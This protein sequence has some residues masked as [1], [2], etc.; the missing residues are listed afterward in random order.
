ME[1][2]FLKIKELQPFRGIVKDYSQRLPFYLDDWIVN[3]TD[4]KILSATLFIFFTSIGPAITFSLLI[5]HGTNGEIGVVEVLLG[6]GVS[7]IIAALFQGFPLVIWGVSGPVSVLTIA[8]RV[9]AMSW[10]LPFLPFFAWSQIWGGVILIL[11]AI[12][13]ASDS[14][15]CITTYTCETFGTLIGTIFL[16][17][18]IRGMVDIFGDSSLA[19]D[20]VLLQFILFIGVAITSYYLAQAHHWKVLFRFLRNAVSEYGAVISITLFSLV[21][22]LASHRLAD[23]IA[24]IPTLRVPSSF[25]TSSGRPWLVD[26]LDI[27]VYGVFAA[28]L[29][30]MIIAILFFFDHNISSLFAQTPKYRLVRGSSFHWDICLMGIVLFFTA[31]LG[32]PPSNGLIP[33][34]PLMTRALS[35]PNKSNPQ[36]LDVLEQRWSNLIQSGMILMAASPPISSVIGLI[37][38]AV[39]YGFFVFMGVVSFDDNSFAYRLYLCIMD[40]NSRRLES[41]ALA[42]L[43][44]SVVFKFTAIQALVCAMMFAVT[45]TPADVAFPVFLPLCVLIRANYLSHIFTDAQLVVL[46]P[47][48][49]VRDADAASYHDDTSDSCKHPAIQVKEVDDDDVKKDHDRNDDEIALS[50][51]LAYTCRYIESTVMQANNDHHHQQQQ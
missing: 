49:P 38:N 42:S 12:F 44:L 26:L 9:I 48:I 36:Q 41:S 45:F 40:P 22:Y 19:F 18:G 46:D 14:V 16:Y 10:K 2:I 6:T 28:M 1:W 32:I 27:P 17:T 37:P 23:G 15:K 39:L 21:P 4:Y 50:M 7:G 33:Q 29:P 31:I 5:D 25:A 34:A 24:S 30:G 51:D 47:A 13:N 43:D 20:S 11:L 3:L 35:S 8:I